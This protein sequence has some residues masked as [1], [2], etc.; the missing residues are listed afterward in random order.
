[1]ILD[2]NF[3]EDMHDYENWGDLGGTACDVIVGQ[4]SRDLLGA[5]L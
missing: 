3:F 5:S 4:L 1:M 2:D